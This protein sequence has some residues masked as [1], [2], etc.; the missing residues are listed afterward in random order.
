MIKVFE[1][2]PALL[3]DKHQKKIFLRKK[4]DLIEYEKY[5]NMKTY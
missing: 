4:I 1:K 3:I 5:Q 2:E